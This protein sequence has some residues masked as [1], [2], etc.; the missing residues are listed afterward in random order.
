MYRLLIT[1][2]M[3]VITSLV[4]LSATQSDEEQL[5]T[6]M[7]GK[8]D[9]LYEILRDKTLE[10]AV[11][12]QK[13]LDEVTPLFDFNL[14]ARL[15]LDSK[16]WK[17]LNKTQQKEF[18]DLFISRVQSSYLS[19]LDLFA[20][21]EVEVKDSVQVK[22]NRIQVTTTLKTNTEAKEI[23]YKFYKTKTEGWLIYDV[24]VVGVSFLQ[25]YR[26]Q[27]ASFLREHSFDELLAELKNAD[28]QPA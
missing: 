25:S 14:M 13:V 4:P 22:P 23:V 1:F 5:K 8:A 2:L 18:S 19:K 16:T 24:D 15:A 20:D 12:E 27:F 10:S 7:S 21:T 17:S 26:S 28:N 3:L 9:R 6:L 11:R